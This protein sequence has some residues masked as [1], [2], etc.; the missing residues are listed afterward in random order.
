M[1][2]SL[3]AEDKSHAEDKSAD[4]IVKPSPFE[5]GVYRDT[6]DPKRIVI[7]KHFSDDF[8]SLKVES[9]D[10]S[11]AIEYVTF[12]DKLQILVTIPGKD[13][14]KVYI[15]KKGEIFLPGKFKKDEIEYAC[16]LY[17]AHTAYWNA[18]RSNPKKFKVDQK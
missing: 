13:L 6:T 11:L 5:V 16:T 2:H 15:F 3:Y 17:L 8:N 9:V 18:L 7:Y 4:K 14:G 1:L 12:G 10:G